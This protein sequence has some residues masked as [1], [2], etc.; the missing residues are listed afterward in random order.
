MKDKTIRGNG[1]FEPYGKVKTIQDN[2]SYKRKKD[3]KH[4][5]I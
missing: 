3:K 2:K 4:F 5:S 1:K